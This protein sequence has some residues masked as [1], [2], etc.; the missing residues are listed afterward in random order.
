[1]EAD[2]R[3]KFVREDLKL[4]A[5]PS[6]SRKGERR[7]RREEGREEEDGDGGDGGGGGGDGGDGGGMERIAT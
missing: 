5:T 1:D 6:Q 2:A 4:R 3:R 7:W